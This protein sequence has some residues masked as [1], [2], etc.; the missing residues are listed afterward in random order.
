VAFF[1]L[2]RPRVAM[3]EPRMAPASFWLPVR[4]SQHFGHSPGS[5]QG[6]T[7]GLSEGDR[8]SI[9]PDERISCPS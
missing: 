6:P 2:E 1:F 5:K 8:L 9:G 4:Y 7:F 3:H